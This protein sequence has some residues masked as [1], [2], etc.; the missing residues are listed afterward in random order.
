VSEADVPPI[1]EELLLEVLNP[2]IRAPETAWAWWTASEPEL[3]NVSP[4]TWLSQGG[5]FEA[6]RV[7]AERF[8]WRLAQ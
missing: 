4:A 8:A 2:A 3:G 5:D 7:Q 1:P 6:V